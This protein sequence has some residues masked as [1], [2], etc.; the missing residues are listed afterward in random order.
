MVNSSN[1]W[2]STSTF[3]SDSEFWLR[4]AIAF[5]S[6]EN[7]PLTIWLDR[8]DVTWMYRLFAMSSLLPQSLVQLS[9]R[10]IMKFTSADCK[11]RWRLLLEITG[12]PPIEVTATSIR[13]WPPD[14]NDEMDWLMVSSK[15]L[16]ILSHSSW[17][18][19]GIK[20]SRVI[21]AGIVITTGTAKASA[22]GLGVGWSTVVTVGGGDPISANVGG[23]L[24]T[25]AN[26]GG[27]LP[28]SAKV[29]GGLPISANVGGGVTISDGGRVSTMPLWQRFKWI[30]ARIDHDSDESDT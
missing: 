23:G 14:K 30:S 12:C 17:V 7:S 16:E 10:V 4:R 25:S 19:G 24:P 11:R 1:E 26:V 9:S 8:P 27:G 15:A 6:I 28:I 29:G 3:A 2:E 20:L 13:L 22:V 21:E 18:V 5:K